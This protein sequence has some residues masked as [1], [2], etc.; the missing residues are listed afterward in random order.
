MDKWLQKSE[1]KEISQKS[2]VDKT[3]NDSQREVTTIST[4]KT[5]LIIGID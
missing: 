4:L 5:F 1:T 3:T 2:P